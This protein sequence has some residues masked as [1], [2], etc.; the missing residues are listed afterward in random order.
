M[1]RLRQRWT[2]FKSAHG[3]LAEGLRPV[4]TVREMGQN[5]PLEMRLVAGPVADVQAATKMCAELVGT[6]F[7]CHPAVFDGQRLAQK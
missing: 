1:A 3:S 5:K 7:M 6:Q 4:V 2:A